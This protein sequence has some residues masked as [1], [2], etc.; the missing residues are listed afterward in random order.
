M[1]VP[2]N[3]CLP[4][5]IIC[6]ESLTNAGIWARVVAY[7]YVGPG[8]GH[9]IC[10]YEYDGRLWTYDQR[11]SIAVSFTDKNDALGIAKAAEIVRGNINK[12]AEAKFLSD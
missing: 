7:Q 8:A 11:G 1:S 9:A 3:A 4:A 10:V 5:A 2:V 6:T 12:V